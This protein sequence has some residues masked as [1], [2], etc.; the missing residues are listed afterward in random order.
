MK[1]RMTVMLSLCL[2]LLLLLSACASGGSTAK[3]AEKAAAALAESMLNAPSE[4]VQ[5]F[6]SILENGEESALTAYK[7]AWEDEKAL[8]NENG[9]K[10]FIEK[11]LNVQKM[12]NE[13]SETVKVTAVKTEPYEEKDRVVRFTVD[14]TV[15][16]TEN[17]TVNGKCQFDEDGKVSFIE[18]DT[19]E[20][21]MTLIAN[22]N[23]DP[24][25]KPAQNCELHL[26]NSACAAHKTA[27]KPNSCF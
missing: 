19:N 14:V 26:L 12:A 5:R 7:D 4:P 2:S 18:L 10:D 20:L 6:G 27:C 23:A 13:M 3:N 25:Q 17:M 21:E 16:D 22:D 9:L 8:C 24:T 1:K 15:N 11:P